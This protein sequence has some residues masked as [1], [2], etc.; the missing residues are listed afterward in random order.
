MAEKTETRPDWDEYFLGIAKAVAARA[1]C[2]RRKVGSVLV[3]DHRVI[4]TGYN[5]AAPGVPGCLEGACPRGK[6][7]YDEIKGL[8]DYDRVGSK[9]FCVANHAE[10]NATIFSTRDTKGATIYITDP[11]CPNCRKLLAAAGIARAVW[12]TGELAGKDMVDFAT[13]PQLS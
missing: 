12:P 5:G 7:T 8:G 1:N 6:A 11:P 2:T 13:F 9:S 3:L 4:S 10:L